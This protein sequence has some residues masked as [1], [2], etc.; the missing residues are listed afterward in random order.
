MV[1][2]AEVRDEGTLFAELLRRHRL[3]AELTQETLAERAGLS[4]N[5][6]QKLESGGTRPQRET[7]RRLASALQLTPDDQVAFQ[8]AGQPHPR[9]PAETDDRQGQAELPTPLTSFIGRAREK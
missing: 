4:V 5:A 6:I 9:R 1:V 3:S 7:L 8:T 2:G